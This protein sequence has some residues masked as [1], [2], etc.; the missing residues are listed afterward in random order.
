MTDRSFRGR[1]LHPD[2]AVEFEIHE[3]SGIDWLELDLGVE[4]E[5]ERIPLAEPIAA[6]LARPDFTIEAIDEASPEPVMLPLGDGRLLALPGR[7]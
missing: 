3:S 1:V 6:L 7:A 2:A 5:G 4:I